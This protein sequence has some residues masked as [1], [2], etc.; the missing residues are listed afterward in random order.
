MGNSKVK[1][2]FKAL[3]GD[4]LLLLNVYLSTHNIS[5]CKW[6]YVLI[7]ALTVFSFFFFFLNSI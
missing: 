2:G 6:L 5:E 1:E 7:S 4:D 3:L